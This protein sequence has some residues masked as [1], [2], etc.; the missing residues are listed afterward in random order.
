MWRTV[1]KLSLPGLG[2]DFGMGI[3]GRHHS[4]MSVPRLTCFD[5][6]ARGSGHGEMTGS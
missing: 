6:S 2:T 3:G 5:Q 4:I 1:P